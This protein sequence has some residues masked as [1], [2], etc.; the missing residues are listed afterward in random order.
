MIIQQQKQYENENKR[1]KLEYKEQLDVLS[2]QQD[3]YEN[4]DKQQEL[5]QKEQ[6][7][8]QEEE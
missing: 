3:E 6:L 5:E 7:Q 2:Q 8:K 4:N 1:Q